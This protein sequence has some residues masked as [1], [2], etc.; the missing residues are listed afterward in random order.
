MRRLAALFVVVLCAGCAIQTD[1]APQVIAEEDRAG[2]GNREPVEEAAGSNRIY[3]LAPTEP[4]EQQQLR[5]V[6]RDTTSTSGAVLESL[7]AGPNVDEQAAGV[8]TAIPPTL[9]VNSVRAVGRVLIVDLTDAL[10]E[11]TTAAISLAVA[12]IVATAT[13]LESVTEVRLLVNG[14][15]QAWPLGNGGLAERP[16]TI[17]DYPGLVESSQPAYPAIPIAEV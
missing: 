5:A 14:E 17:F 7:L 6:L 8:G 11:L 9:E 15:Q 4:G 16:L 1:D 10:D 13:D 2:F 12:Q 3:L